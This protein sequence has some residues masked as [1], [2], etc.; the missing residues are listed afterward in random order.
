MHSVTLPPSYGMVRFGARRSAGSEDPYAPYK[1]FFESFVPPTEAQLGQLAEAATRW[2]I[3]KLQ[4]MNS[5]PEASWERLEDELRKQTL[6]RLEQ[7]NQ[8]MQAS[9]RSY[10]DCF[11]QRLK[12]RIAV[13]SL[14]TIKSRVVSLETTISG[15]PAAGILKEACKAAY[16]GYEI[17][18]PRSTAIHISLIEKTVRQYDWASNRYT[19]TIASV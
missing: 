9:F 5:L 3:S 4:T 16:D 15:K 11:P 10:Q 18:F 14:D 2:W 19:E 7:E 17:V 13:I 6:S 1:A 8:E 12:K